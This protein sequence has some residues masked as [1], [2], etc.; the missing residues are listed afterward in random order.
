MKQVIYGEYDRYGFSVLS[1]D[2]SC[3]LWEGNHALD[4]GQSVPPGSI[5]SVGLRTLRSWCIENTRELA[6]E[7]KA[8]YGGIERREE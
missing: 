8:I 3:L 1:T 7:H 6:K 4:S 5:N 2:G